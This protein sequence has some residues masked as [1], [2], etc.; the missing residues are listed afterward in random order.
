MPMNPHRLSSILAART[1]IRQAEGIALADRAAAGLDRATGSVW[2]QL[3]AVLKQPQ[4]WVTNYRAAV[5]VLRRLTPALATDLHSRLYTLADWGHR[6]AAKLLADTLP[7]D[8]L[9][10]AAP[11]PVGESH[12]RGRG[13]SRTQ[14]AAVLCRGVHRH[15]GNL[16]AAVLARLTEDEDDPEPAEPPHTADQLRELFRQLLFPPPPL[17]VINKIIFGSTAGQ[18]WTER[19][20]SLSRLAPAEVLASVV[21]NGMAAGKS[22]REIAREIRPH[23]DGV[24]S[25]AAR[26]ARTEGLRCLHA[27]QQHAHDQI[28]DIIAGYQIHSV[29]DQNVRPAHR[30]RN[31]AVWMKNSGQSK[32]EALHLENGADQPPDGPNC[33]CYLSVIMTPP[34]HIVNSPEKMAVFTTNAGKVVPDPSVYA[35]WFQQAD[36]RRQ[37]IAVGA[38]KHAW[39]TEQFGKDFG[40]ETFVS[41]TGH[42]L[43]LKALKAESDQAR[44]KRIA[45]VRDVMAQRRDL[46]RTT[47][48]FG[49]LPPENPGNPPKIPSPAV[50]KPSPIGYTLTSDKPQALAT[51]KPNMVMPQTLRSTVLQANN[52]MSFEVRTIRYHPATGFEGYQVSTYRTINGKTVK[53]IEV[54]HKTNLAA[55]QADHDSQVAKIKDQAIKAGIPLTD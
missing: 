28:D 50:D 33:R 3:L 12:A 26:I 14:R 5:R 32:Q 11:V 30:L 9:R 1:G 23:V 35:D 24:R 27:L 52:G 4:D 16:S 15:G 20:A 51:G 34:A 53:A 2:Q 55:A 19:I 45:K 7:L 21:A 10:A 18:S 38:R 17:E 31:G 36:V 41:P 6:S 39:A 8:Y 54:D 22:Q 46:I 43:S 37:R 44:A 42:P 49:F 25:S 40:W 29:L 48:T 13:S 47:S